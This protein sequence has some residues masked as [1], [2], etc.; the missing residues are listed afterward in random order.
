MERTE[1]IENFLNKIKEIYGSATGEKIISNIR[2]KPYVSFRINTIK[3]EPTKVLQEL[4]ELGFEIESGS[5]P[6]SFYIKTPPE[7]L[8]L[9]RTEVFEKGEIYIQNFS[10]MIPAFVLDPQPGENVLDMCAAPGSKTTHI[11]ALSGNKATITAV[12]NNTNR[13]NALKRNVG[14]QGA[15]NVNFIRESSQRLFLSHPQY[16]NYFD[17]VLCD[18]PCSNEG[19]IRDLDSHDLSFWNIKNAK[20]LSLLQK[21]LVSSAIATLK[22]GGTLVYSTCTYSIEENEQVIDW[23]L[24]KFPYMKIREIKLSNIPFLPGMVSW[25]DKTFSPD[26]AMTIRILPDDLYEAF[27]IVKL[28]KTQG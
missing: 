24:K 17:K 18:V 27:F 23:I 11:A 10:S 2:T 21:K 16:L 26:I 7:D 15:A 5:L 1:K 3:S 6:N 8:V 4:K 22:N 14:A 13:F 25:K 20:K 19:L 28:V 12:E 9:S